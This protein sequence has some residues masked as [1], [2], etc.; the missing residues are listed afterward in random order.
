MI[1]KILSSSANFGAV[2]YNTNKINKGNG[3]LM[4]FENFPTLLKDVIPHPN[5]IKD[6]LQAV[7]SLNKRVKKPQFHATISCEK[8]EYTKEELTKIGREYMSKMGYS[9]QPYIIVFHNDTNNNHVHIVSTRVDVQ[10]KKIDHNFENVR[11]QK[12]L[13]DILERDF[14]VSESKK[15]ENLLDYKLSSPSQ[16]KTLLE[17]NHFQFKELDNTFKVYKGGW[18]FIND[19]Q[20]SYTNERDKERQNQLKAIFKSYA[21]TYNHLLTKNDKGIWACEMTDKLKDSLNIDIMFHDSKRSEKPFGFTIID[22]Q[23]K[24]VYKGSEIFDL[25]VFLDKEVSIFEELENP[26][27]YEKDYFEKVDLIEDNLTQELEEE[28]E[29]ETS[30]FQSV[31]NV[32]AAS[33]SGGGS[34]EQNEEDNNKRKR[35]RR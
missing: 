23:E 5:E 33:N 31:A 28:L 25:K 20:P 24:A 16:F 15:L 26:I 7:S 4:S 29:E 19:V 13:Q 27:I 34:E 14:G 1:V 18:I 10:G 12:H 17:K 9:N 2:Q 3:E 8:E 32:I 30:I 21:L 11:S 22:N 35:R 6:Y